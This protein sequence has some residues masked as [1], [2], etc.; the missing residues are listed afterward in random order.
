MAHPCPNCPD[1][2][3]SNTI[4]SK[5][6]QRINPAAKGKRT[7]EGKSNINVP[8]TAN[9]SVIFELLVSK[10]SP[11]I[12]VMVIKAMKGAQAFTVNSQ[13]KYGWYRPHISGKAKPINA[14]KI[15]DTSHKIPPRCLS[16]TTNP[17]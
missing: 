6:K 16:T 13:G 10:E 4:P 1:V 15:I 12:T 7:G 9:A 5:G 14:R 17:V 11:A 2:V 3:L 8:R